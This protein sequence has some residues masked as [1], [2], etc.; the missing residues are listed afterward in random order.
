MKL[1]TNSRR[2]RRSERGYSLLEVLIVL[3]IIALI[4]T[5]VGP[6]LFAQLDRS[7]ATA[8]RVQI[9]SVMA[10]VETMR[11]DIGRYPTQA[12][13]LKLLVEPPTGGDGDTGGWRGPYLD[14]AV[15]LDPWGAAYVY[16]APVQPDERPD[17]LSYGGDG[18][19]GGAGVAADITLN[20][21]S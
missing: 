3:S 21:S 12:E 19:A 2:R 18:K 20:R 16:T 14:A 10:A 17:I 11:L 1:R 6:R 7:K 13:G 9:Q 15:P 4:A 8:A 5:F